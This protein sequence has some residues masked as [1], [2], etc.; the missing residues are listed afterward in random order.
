MI[1][2]RVAGFGQ[3]VRRATS[4]SMTE[5]RAHAGVV[6]A[7]RIAAVMLALLAGLAHSPSVRSQAQP[8]TPLLVIAHAGVPETR[9]DGDALRAIFL[10]KRTLWSNGR[11]IVPLNQP[12]GHP[13]R[14]TFDSRMLGFDGQQAARY[15]IDARIRYGAEAPMSIAS[16]SLLVRVVKQL[17][18][19]IGY[20]RAASV[21]AGVR[22][23]ARVERSGVS[24]P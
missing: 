20:V 15:W 16:E 13:V 12:A 8:E 11:R 24:P 1:Q 23:V 6:P 17:A 22:V 3:R 18:G 14:L 5:H 19:S 2:L 10:R 9:L 4:V 21:P 7:A